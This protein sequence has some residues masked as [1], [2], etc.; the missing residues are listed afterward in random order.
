[1]LFRSGVSGHAT[2]MHNHAI[3]LAPKVGDG[4]N[5]LCETGLLE[6]NPLHA[7]MV[8]VTKKLDHAFLVNMVFTPEG[9]SLI[10]IYRKHKDS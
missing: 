6:G 8:E 7:D 4:C 2:I 9:L 3:A 1:M 5:P 10:H